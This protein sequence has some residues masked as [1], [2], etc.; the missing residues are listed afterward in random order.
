[1]PVQG[2]EG[3]QAWEPCQ[4]Q[5]RAHLQVLHLG[6]VAEAALA[7][8]LLLL[9]CL[10]RA[11]WRQ[12][13]HARPAQHA[14]PSTVL[15]LEAACHLP[16][17]RPPAQRHDL[18]WLLLATGH[19]MA[20]DAVPGRTVAGRWQAGS[21][22]A[23]SACTRGCP[24]P[25]GW[26]DPP[27]VLQ[28]HGEPCQAVVALQLALHVCG[29][30]ACRPQVSPPACLAAVTQH[31][32]VVQGGNVP[33]MCHTRHHPPGIIPARPVAQ[34]AHPVHGCA[35]QRSRVESCT[36]HAPTQSLPGVVLYA[37]PWLQLHTAP[38][39]AGSRAGRAAP[40]IWKALL[41]ACSW[42]GLNWAGNWRPFGGPSP[43]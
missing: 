12:P 3:W 24:R 18:W 23:G 32:P 6:R 15:R 43:P 30:H 20:A 14:P 9:L 37:R 1:M 13:R 34:P 10:L 35:A 21:M 4:G 2:C 11:A 25:A 26:L 39:R 41:L 17:L 28:R 36:L 42:L 31:S 38:A 22:P 19:A 16:S 40:G 8:L 33:Q 5:S 29:A 27:V 7:Q